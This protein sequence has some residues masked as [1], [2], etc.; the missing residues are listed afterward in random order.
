MNRDVLDIN[1]WAAE[2]LAMIDEEVK[3]ARADALNLTAANNE[4]WAARREMR[5]KL[6]ARYGEIIGL[7]MYRAALE[8]S[9]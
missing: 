9:A 6:T 5:E 1:T 3:K 4:K 7:I 8:K 2:T